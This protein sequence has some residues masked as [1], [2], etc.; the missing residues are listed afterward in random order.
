MTFAERKVNFSK[1]DKE[2][3]NLNKKVSKS[4]LTFA[5]AQKA[6]LVDQV[7][8]SIDNNDIKAL[9]KITG[10]PQTTE[11]MIEELY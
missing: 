7:K 11:K 5:N 6:T 8:K 1:L 3:T 2:M 9:N 10:N 4:Y